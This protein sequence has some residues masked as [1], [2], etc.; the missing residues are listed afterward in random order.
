MEVIGDGIDFFNSG[1]A[2]KRI[3]EKQKE[4]ADYAVKELEKTTATWN[5]DV[6]FEIRE[7]W[8]ETNVY[9]RN[10]VWNWLNEGTSAHPVAPRAGGAMQ[11]KT[12]YTPK[13]SVGSATSNSG[14]GTGS[15]AYSKGHTVSGVEARNWTEKVGEAVSDYIKDDDL[16]FDEM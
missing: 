13:T 3:R 5:T 11:F 9:T 8:K 7:G 4:I 14:G 10:K 15:F 6:K 2:I 1:R 16:W 12:G